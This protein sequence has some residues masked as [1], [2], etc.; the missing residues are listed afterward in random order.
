MDQVDRVSDRLADRV[1]WQYT[2]TG[3]YKEDKGRWNIRVD[4]SM[5]CS[6]SGSEDVPVGAQVR[7]IARVSS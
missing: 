2:R 7:I 4:S 5:S 3:Q 1:G 6:D